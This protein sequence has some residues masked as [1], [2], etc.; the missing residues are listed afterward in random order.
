VLLQESVIQLQS[1]A[2]TV[3]PAHLVI[4]LSK[5][6]M[7]AMLE[8]ML[9]QAEVVAA[10]PPP[11]SEPVVRERLVK[12]IPVEILTEFHHLAEEAVAV[13]VLQVVMQQVQMVATVVT[14]KHLL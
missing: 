10:A 7:V 6:V 5:A 8:L 4:P 11:A 9:L 3:L 1:V 12:G 2:V 13:K 14:E